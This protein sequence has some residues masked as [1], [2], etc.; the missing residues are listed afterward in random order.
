VLRAGPDYGL[1]SPNSS[2]PTRLWERDSDDRLTL[3]NDDERRCERDEG[4]YV[5]PNVWMVHQPPRAT[6]P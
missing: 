4:V 6:E 1:P 5:E 3:V 2:R